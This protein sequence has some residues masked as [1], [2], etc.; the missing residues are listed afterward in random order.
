MHAIYIAN[1][2]KYL[3]VFFIKFN[4]MFVLPL[5]SRKT[6]LL[7]NNVIISLKITIAIKILKMM[8]VKYLSIHVFKFFIIRFYYLL[9]FCVHYSAGYEL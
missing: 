1:I 7:N 3:L 6:K 5:Q 9:F 8:A 4:I 2:Y